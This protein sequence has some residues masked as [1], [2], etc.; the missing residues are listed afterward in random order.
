MPTHT[1]ASYAM[2]PSPLR[3]HFDYLSP[4]AYLAWTQIHTLAE[5]HHR[6]VEPVPVLFAALLDHW[7]TK[8]PAE[9]PPKRIYVFKDALRNAQRLGVS[10][11]P[12]PAHPFNPLLALRASSL[13][14]QPAQ[15][16]ALISALFAEA[17]GGG[18]GVT[19]A[20]VISDCAS[21]C[22]LDAATI[23]AT[24]NEPVAKNTVRDA[25]TRAIA[26]GVFGIPTVIADGELFWGLDAL[27]HLE[28]HLRGEAPID[29]A[30]IAPWS[31]ITSAAVRPAVAPPP[32]PVTLSHEAARRSATAWVNAWNHRDLDAIVAH[33]A[34]DVQVCS[35]RVLERTGSRDG[36]LRGKDALRAY[37]ALGLTI[38]GLH[39]DLVDV[40][41]GIGAMTVIYRRETGVLVTD[42]C[43]LNAEGRIVRMVACYSAPPL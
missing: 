33:Y 14:M 35:P 27:P 40:T 41:V 5:R 13:P 39:F 30:L 28:D 25:T 24:A 7:G 8:G 23:V 20:S 16:I 43:E 15:R 26:E 9:V 31:H 21:R 1:E 10:L 3:F 29:D 18:R 12:P 34:D 38:P 6:V 36:W 37:F 4:Y 19:D 42:T 11:A 2:I 22:G 32:A 17:W